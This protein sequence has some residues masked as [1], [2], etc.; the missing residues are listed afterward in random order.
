LRT[1][2]G[3]NDLIDRIAADRAFANVDL[4]R[5]L[6]PFQFIGRAP[7]QVDEFIAKEIVPIRSKYGDLASDAELRV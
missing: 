7:Q 4:T 6:D 1:E 3:K 2:G 5:L